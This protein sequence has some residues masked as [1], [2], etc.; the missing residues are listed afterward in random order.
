MKFCF[1]RAFHFT[2]YL[3]FSSNGLVSVSRQPDDAEVGLISSATEK[4]L[5]GG[6]V[7]LEPN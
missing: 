1:R 3:L 2:S 6:A 5:P 4:C 7:R